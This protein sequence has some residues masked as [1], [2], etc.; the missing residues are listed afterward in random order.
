M[1][2][3]KHRPGIDDADGT[4]RIARSTTDRMF[5]YFLPTSICRVSDRRVM[6]LLVVSKHIVD[7]ISEGQVTENAAK[8]A[9]PQGGTPNLRHLM[10]SLQSVLSQ[11]NAEYER[12]RDKLSRNLP[13]GNVKV[14]VLAKL[15]DWHWERRRPYIEQMVILQ[16]TEC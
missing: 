3:T 16:V 15:E 12:E 4:D 2:P 11:I 9:Q 7:L 10:Q 14:R 1:K 6:L 8:R 13:D 5:F